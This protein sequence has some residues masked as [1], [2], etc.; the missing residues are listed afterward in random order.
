M[1]TIT[2]EDAQKVWEIVQTVDGGCYECVR[3]LVED[4]GQVFPE[5]PWNE[6]FEQWRYE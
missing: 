1:S 2:I 5:N 4:L 6:W 3:G